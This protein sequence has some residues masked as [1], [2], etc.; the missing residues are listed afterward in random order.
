MNKEKRRPTLDELK[1]LHPSVLY[2]EM[3]QIVV[4][5]ESAGMEDV[6]QETLNVWMFEPLTPEKVVE[7][8]EKLQRATGS[9]VELDAA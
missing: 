2:L 1:A 7:L 9:T 8:R 5:A 6:K 3:A 4:D